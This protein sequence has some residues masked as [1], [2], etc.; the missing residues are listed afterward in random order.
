MVMA[1]CWGSEIADLNMY[2]LF[3]WL[4]DEFHHFLSK[5]LSSSKLT[6][7]FNGGWLPGHILNMLQYILNVSAV[8]V[9]ISSQLEI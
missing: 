5:G 7:I 8:A 3:L 6:T 1:K 2:M 4:V 9:E